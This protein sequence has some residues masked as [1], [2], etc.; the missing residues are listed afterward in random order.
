MATITLSV[1]AGAHRK[2]KARA[3]RDS[4]GGNVILLPNDSVQWNATGSEEFRV[5]FSDPTLDDSHKDK[6]IFPF[7]KPDDGPYGPN[8]AP[9]LRVI[10]PGNPRDLTV[11]IPLDIKYEVYCI[12]TPGA[13]PLDPMI[14]IRPPVVSDSVALAVTT[15]VLGAAVGSA[16]TYLL[17]T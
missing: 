9:S 15:G 14:I 7:E 2:V 1:T 6:W 11:G 10:G 12:S 8:N 4:D 3:K 13:T 17:L 5:I 16:V